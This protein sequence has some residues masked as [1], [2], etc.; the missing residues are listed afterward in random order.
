MRIYS[1]TDEVCFR[2][3][4]G[5]GSSDLFQERRRSQVVT[6]KHFYA[7]ISDKLPKRD[8]RR[9]SPEYPRVQ[10]F[11]VIYFLIQN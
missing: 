11:I 9:K 7:Y 2:A 10:A 5:A 8:L 1:E 6:R 3:P 4:V